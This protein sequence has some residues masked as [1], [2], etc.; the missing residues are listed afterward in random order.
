MNKSALL[1]LFFL[2]F[3]LSAQDSDW[4]TIKDLDK[5]FRVDFPSEP[6]P[7]KQTVSSA[8]GELL[9]D[10]NMLDMTA[11]PGAKVLLYMTSYTEYPKDFTDYSN[12]ENINNMLDGSVNGAVNNVNGKLIS[13]EKC[14]FNKFK[15][16]ESR[17][18]LTS[19]GIIIHMKTFLVDNVMYLLQTLYYKGSDDHLV[20]E[21]K[22]FDSFELIRVN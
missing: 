21:K 16:V 12:E 22:F 19:G 1:L 8:A 20:D 18:E 3:N 9:M 13:S 14:E 10:M 15:C 7:Q 5:G 17:I 11:D 2:A 6:K 4:V